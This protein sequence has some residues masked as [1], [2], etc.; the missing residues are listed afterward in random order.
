MRPRIEEKKCVSQQT[1]LSA[2]IYAQTSYAHRNKKTSVSFV[3]SLT[4]A[5]MH[6]LTRTS[7][8]SREKST[9]S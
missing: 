3:M 9:H 7:H 5:N 1:E 8:R 2:R 4:H 6:R